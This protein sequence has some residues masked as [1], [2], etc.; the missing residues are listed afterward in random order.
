M[1]IK[2][3]DPEGLQNLI[4]N[5]I[6]LFSLKNHIHDTS[7]INN[8]DDTLNSLMERNSY[9]SILNFP[10]VGKTGNLYIDTS[11]NKTY[12][13]D[14]NDLKYYCVGSDYNDIKVISCGDATSE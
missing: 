6:K 2:Y 5:S 7:E 9:D 4:E 3:L 12:R 14:D 11:Q 13:W 8:L 1:E 10:N